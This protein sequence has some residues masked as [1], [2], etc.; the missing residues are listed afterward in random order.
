[1]LQGN[2][3]CGRLVRSVTFRN[4]VILEWNTTK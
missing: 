2:L 4:L 1:V 3:N